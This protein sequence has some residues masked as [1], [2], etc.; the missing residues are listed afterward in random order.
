MKTKSSYCSFLSKTPRIT[1]CAAV[2]ALFLAAATSASASV[3]TGDTNN[4]VWSSTNSTGGWTTGGVPNGA[5]AVATFDNS[6]QTTSRVTV[7]D[8]NVT[9][10]QI[11]F[12]GA[13]NWQRQINIGST[14][15]L[16]INN[17][18]SQ[19][20]IENASTGTTT[21]RLNF[22]SGT[23]MLNGDLLLKNSGSSTNPGGSIAFSSGL[24]GTGNLTVNNASN[25]FNSGRISLGNSNSFVGNTVI[26]KGILSVGGSSNA[27]GTGTATTNL[28]TLGST[29]NGSASLVSTGS[30]TGFSNNITIV[31]DA[32]ANAVMTLGTYA[33]ISGTSTSGAVTTFS[34]TVVLNTGLTVYSNTNTNAK[35]TYDSNVKF[36]NILSG[37][38]GVTK[39][40]T[41]IATLSGK[42]TFTGN[43][44]VDDGTLILA[45]NG[46]TRFVIQ[47][48]NTSNQIL[49]E[50]TLDISGL[51]RL[52]ISSLT[53]SSGT[54]HLVNAATLSE[55]YGAT[56]GLFLDNGTTTT[57]L[58]QV[59]SSTIYKTSDNLWSFDTST[60]NLVMV[61]EVASLNILA[62]GL[63]L[64][65]RRI[66]K[67]R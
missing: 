33:T 22:G 10:G 11:T 47:N 66:G 42:N 24:S 41:G 6:A 40:G 8:S 48:N 21:N 9:V 49:G 19:A 52:D 56:F 18:G 36:T 37:V 16:T 55:T 45:A 50:S 31:G 38:G 7:L 46:E 61:P 53:D 44:I 20:V 32:G 39:T 43:I 34:G 12:I 15:S 65:G 54:W 58:S 63:L 29:N 14:Y 4:A 2:A 51:F 67:R 27:L 3:W 26:Q 60:G 30:G 62:A 1:P 25:D 64:A 5:G 59:G 13:K 23:V 57:A 35:G 17:N 28:I